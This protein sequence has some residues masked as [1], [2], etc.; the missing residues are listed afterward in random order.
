MS[1]HTH[2]PVLLVNDHLQFAISRNISDVTVMVLYPSS[3]SINCVFILTNCFQF[4]LIY[5]DKVIY[6]WSF[7]FY[8]KPRHDIDVCECFNHFRFV[9]NELIETERDYVRD[10][11]LVVEVCTL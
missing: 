5:P 2:T 6:N 4:I 3:L 8:F 7:N 10:L 9:I 11:G 1:P